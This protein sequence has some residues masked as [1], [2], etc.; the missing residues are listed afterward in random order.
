MSSPVEVLVRCTRSYQH[1]PGQVH[2]LQGL[3]QHFNRQMPQVSEMD[4]Y[5]L[6]LDNLQLLNI[7]CPSWDK[8]QLEKDVKQLSRSFLKIA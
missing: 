4:F 7:P 1:Q 8:Q 6:V 2:Y 5:L 3:Y